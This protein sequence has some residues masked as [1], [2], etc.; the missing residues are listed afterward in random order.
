MR[1]AAQADE[2]ARPS[3]TVLGVMSVEGD[4]HVANLLTSELRSAAVETQG[5]RVNEREITRTQIEFAHRCSFY[6]RDCL[7]RIAVSVDTDQIIYGRMTRTLELD[8][9]S[10][11]LGLV[12]FDRSES[13]IVA[14]YE[15]E[16]REGSSAHI[17]GEVARDAIRNLAGAATPEP[18]MVVVVPEPELEPSIPVSAPTYDWLAYSFLGAAGL[19]LIGTIVAWVSLADLQDD[20]DFREFRNYVA[21]NA[22]A[23]A[24]A[25]RTGA[26]PPTLVERANSV[27]GQA[28]TLEVMQHVFL[29]LTGVFSLASLF[30]LWIADAAGTQVE[31]RPSVNPDR[32]HLSLIYHF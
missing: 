23:E 13:R 9:Y 30:A 4:D 27:C 18:P 17:I 24:A 2:A 26:A 3:L 11:T 32:A 28:D 1:A 8:N 6:A 14:R 16:I 19:S 12:L 31:L 25:G 15:T 5:W 22:C 29:A 10:Y 7:Q 20:G 21:G